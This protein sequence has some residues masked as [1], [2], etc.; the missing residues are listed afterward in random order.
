MDGTERG[1][2][3]TNAF[4]SM[5][6]FSLLATGVLAGAL[7]WEHY[8]RLF[9]WQEMD[10]AAVDHVVL[11]WCL[12]A[13]SLAL[14]A[15]LAICGGWLARCERSRTGWLFF[16]SGATLLFLWLVADLR[17]RE[18]TGSHLLGLVPY[19]HEEDPLPWAG[20]AACLAGP[21]LSVLVTVTA[22]TA[23]CLWL[24]HRLIRRLA[25]RWSWLASRW[26]VRGAAGLVAMIVFGV[27]PAQYC[28]SAP[29]VAERLREAM[30]IDIS[31]VGSDLAADSDLGRFRAACDRQMGLQYQAVHARLQKPQPVD[32]RARLSDGPRPN[33]VVFLLESLRH[34][35]LDA[36]TMP[37]L[38][39]R[40]ASGLWL[41][42]HYAGSNVSHHG[43]F[44]L[45]Y[46][47]SPF[48][49]ERHL[50][51]G[52]E[53]QSCV[54]L[55]R[56]GYN[57]HFFSCGTVRWWRMDTFI[58]PTTFDDV[59]VAPEA[60]WAKGDRRVLREVGEI[61]RSR[62]DKP[63]FVVAFLVSTH[64]PYMY[65]PECE[66]HTPV[67]TDFTA[68]DLH[69]RQSLREPLKNRFRN[70]AGFL[71]EEID[72]LLDS[73]DPAQ[74]LVIVTGDHGEAIFDDA[75]LA[76]GTKASDVQLRTPLAMFG[77]GLAPGRVEGLTRHADVLPTLLHALAGQ[78][79]PLVGC[80][81][82]DLLGD[83][84]TRDELVL[85]PFRAAEPR[86]LLLIRAE[87]RLKLRVRLDRP[88]LHTVGFVSPLDT[89]DL[90]GLPSYS[91][92]DQWTNL[93]A[94]ELERLTR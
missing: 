24:S 19:L 52:I 4:L 42:R 72:R 69:L 92:I 16:A 22:G 90:Q 88:Q 11:L 63:K 20:G 37:R 21:V 30:P 41:K 47:R 3:G 15:P 68:P 14:L 31:L 29:I 46:G 86:E 32:R 12:W 2:P 28:C 39:K 13:K 83:D 80:H 44:S 10:L 75:T 93:L 33:V 55:R 56:S 87:R 81:G 77:A 78:T 49:C 85:A 38:A 34:D 7:E 62:P 36:A 71:D 8:R 51:A 61:L 67:L 43:V 74:N 50:D 82:R 94:G 45:L 70:A 25:G 65:P 57:C 48:V 84:G 35:A 58:N 64:Y 40:A 6:A 18:I 53:P 91:E 23:A 54:T 59:H 17:V 76:H 89:P 9:R 60:D 66:H 27:M 73:L 1:R 79:V 26:S 5:L